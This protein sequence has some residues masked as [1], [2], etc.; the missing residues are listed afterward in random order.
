MDN[1]VATDVVTAEQAG[2]GTVSLD[3]VQEVTLITTGLSAEF[4]RNSGSQE[5]II[6]AGASNEIHGDAYWYLQNSALNA[7]DFSIPQGK[8]PRSSRICG[9]LRSADQ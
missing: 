5:Q 7:R 2:V 6:T 3:A 1:A 4:G 8:R 9:D